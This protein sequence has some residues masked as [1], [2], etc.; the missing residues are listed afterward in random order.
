MTGCAA[1]CGSCSTGR[2][3]APSS[4]AGSRASPASTCRCSCRVQPHYTAAPIFDGVDDPCIDGRL[5]LLPGYA[6]VAV[7]DLPDPERPRA[8]FAPAEH[9]A[10][11]GAARAAW[12][13]RRPGPRSTCSSACA[14]VAEAP[15][16][17][18]HPTIVAR[19]RAP[20]R[21]REGGFARSPRRRGPDQ[22][23]RPAEHGFDRE[24]PEEVDAA[25]RWAW[26]HAEPWRLP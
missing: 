2:W 26:E 4:C 21:A 3:C 1:T 16:G 25:L 12:A 24:D 19:R 10:L 8:V 5:A 13:S 17:E 15:A 18:R 23:R 6:E 9:R 14:G 7:P 20:V 22:G 11:R